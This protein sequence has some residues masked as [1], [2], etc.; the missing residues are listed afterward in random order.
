MAAKSR[1]PATLFLAVKSKYY[2]SSKNLNNIIKIQK[3]FFFKFG[4]KI[5]TPT[6]PAQTE[7]FSHVELFY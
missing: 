3:L 4:L 6:E 5:L 1:L 2:K 7:L